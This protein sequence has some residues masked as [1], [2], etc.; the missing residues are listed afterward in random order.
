MHLLRHPRN[1]AL[2]GLLFIAI[3]LA[4]FFLVA[5]LSVFLAESLAERGPADMGAASVIYGTPLASGSMIIC[6]FLGFELA[7]PCAALMAV[8]TT[9]IFQADF[10]LLIYFLINGTMAAYWIRNCRERKVFIKAGIDNPL[11]YR[12]NT[13]MLLGDAKKMTESIVKAM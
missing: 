4:V 2:L 11:F 8:L 7:L 10:T 13:M 12:D 9:I 6:L 5:Q 3:V 1:A